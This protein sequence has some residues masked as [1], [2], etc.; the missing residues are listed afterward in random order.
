MLSQDL[1]PYSLTHNVFQDAGG[2]GGQQQLRRVQGIRPAL[3][4]GID[5]QLGVIALHCAAV[6]VDACGGDVVFKHVVS[7]V[8]S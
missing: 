5:D 6:G 7:P 3:E 4:I 1:T 2:D 8:C